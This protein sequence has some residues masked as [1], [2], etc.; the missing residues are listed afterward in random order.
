[1]FPAPHD[2]RLWPIEFKGPLPPLQIVDAPRSVTEH[3]QAHIDPTIDPKTAKSMRNLLLTVYDHTGRSGH[4][5]NCLHLNQ[6]AGKDP[7][8]AEK[9]MPPIIAECMRENRILRKESRQIRG[10]NTL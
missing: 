6:C 7:I 3:L 4:K 2:R 5:R 1:M 10:F 8:K 9:N